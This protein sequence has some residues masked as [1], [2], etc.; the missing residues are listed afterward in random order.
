MGFESWENVWGCW[1]GM[2]PRDSEA[3]RRVSNMLRYFGN[4]GFLTN[5]IRIRSFCPTR[6]QTIALW[7]LIFDHFGQKP[8]FQILDGNHL[9]QQFKVKQFLFL[10]S[11]LD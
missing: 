5:G 10:H 3:T 6:Q 1:N 2:T 8:L 7:V 9:L 11:H 4:L